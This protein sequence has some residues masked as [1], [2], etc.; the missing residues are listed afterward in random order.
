MTKQGKLLKTLTFLGLG[1][2]KSLPW[3]VNINLVIKIVK[4]CSIFLS[5][6][7]VQIYLVC[8]GP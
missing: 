4:C 5:Q 2:V 8:F 1:F 3:L 7:R 6:N